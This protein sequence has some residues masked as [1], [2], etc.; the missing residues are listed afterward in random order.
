M[1]L[2]LND[3][4]LFQ[5]GAFI[6]NEWIQQ[7][8]S[9]K[10]YQVQNPATGESIAEVVECGAV[11]TEKAIQEASSAFKSW[12]QRTA[13]SRA[14]I[15][16]RWHQEIVNARDD[17]T[18]IM[19]LECGK[20]LP[21]S[22]NEFDSGVESITWFA[23]ECKRSNGDII[24]TPADDKQFFVLK[25]PVG[26]VGAITP[27]NFPFSMITRKVS[28][29]LAAGCTVCLKPAELTPLTAFALAEL[30]KRAGIPKGVL[31]IV[32]G[33][34]IAI[35]KAFTDSRIVRKLAFTGST[36]V[37]KLLYAASSDTMKKVSLELGGNAPYIV[38]E[39]ADVD[40]A[41]RDVVLSSYRNAGQTC[42]CTNRVFVHENIYDKFNDA[43]SKQVAKL[44][45]GDG[46]QPGI[47]HGPLIS[48]T[49]V[50]EV[51]AKVQDA[52]GK[53]GVVLAGGQRPDFGTSSPLG[54][55][56]FY[57]PTVITNAT[58]D[59]RV[60]KEEIF[61]PITP[62][63]K[64]SSDAEV[65]QMAN[66][67]EYGLA[68]YFYTQNVTRVWRVA[69][70]LEYGMVGVNQ[71]AITSEVAPFGGVKES[72]LG[73]EHSKYGLDEFQDKK[74]VCLGLGKLDL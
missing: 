35:G 46:L 54:G 64:F 70:A 61:G 19:T 32:S 2:E 9:G 73:R 43:L 14:S 62:V 52:V 25:Q 4:E 23:E 58:V 53:G 27:W 15:L 34:A 12:S 31:N 6:G 67:T 37:G 7:S 36:R 26:V 13:K 69:K 20:P 24:E 42:I 3:K 11:E 10:R 5:T 22:R 47:S 72:G 39:D 56:F 55:G 40:I 29:A 44:R 30:G 66:D 45:L 17:I 1:P 41:A 16:H 65:V 21:E 60:F 57:E 59:M 74:T 48:K 50:D 8:E 63:F 38:F 68:A 51:H 33:D 71:V 28:P 18:R 49:A